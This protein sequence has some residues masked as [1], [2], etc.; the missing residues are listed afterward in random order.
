M[1]NKIEP[2]MTAI[3]KISV[4]TCSY[5]QAPFLEL[6]M[7]SVLEQRYP[8]LEYLVVDGGSTDGSVALI[9]RYSDS[10]AYRVSEKDHGQ[11]EA[12]NKGLRKSSGEIIGWLCSDD[13]L[14]PGSLEAVAN[15]FAANPSVDAVYGDAILIDVHGKV[16]RAKRE[17]GFSPFSILYD[18]NYIPQ[19]SMFWRRSLM[20]KVGFLDE[21]LHLSMDADYWMRFA[22]LGRVK[23]MRNF[24]SCMRNH[25]AQKVFLD[26][27]G[28]FQ[29]ATLLRLRYSKVFTLDAITKLLKWYARLYRIGYRWVTHGY[30]YSVPDELVHWLSV[31]HKTPSDQSH[32]AAKR[33]SK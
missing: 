22:L 5:Q 7:R 14:F 33:G 21:S 15:Y 3:P 1:S 28:V 10:L 12:L 19:P 8:N 2:A 29:E 20:E 17:M 16:L 30:E 26:R 24:L 23:H 31:L 25:N 32:L 13:L 6:A 4:I 27:P 18:H 11:S 9:E